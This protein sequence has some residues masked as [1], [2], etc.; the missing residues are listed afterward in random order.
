MLG[1]KN[2]RPQECCDA[3]RGTFTRDCCVE[4]THPDAF[5]ALRPV[6]IGT[7]GFRLFF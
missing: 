1:R 4:P 5:K 3:N 7:A 2:A 6:K